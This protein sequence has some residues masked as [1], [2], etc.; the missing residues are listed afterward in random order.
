MLVKRVAT[1]TPPQQQPF[2]GT[3]E[4]A[5]YFP[6]QFDKFKQLVKY[7]PSDRV[8][9]INVDRLHLQV[10]SACRSRNIDII[11]LHHRYL[12]ICLRC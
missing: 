9:T 3:D 6:D 5:I 10:C 12:I 11:F 4:S 7:L 1:D 8:V 2:D